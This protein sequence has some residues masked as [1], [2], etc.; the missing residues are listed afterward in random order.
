MNKLIL[1]LAVLIGSNAYA[2]SGIAT[3]NTKNNYK[4]LEELYLEAELFESDFALEVNSIE[5]YKIEEE[6]ILNFD[7]RM[8]L[9]EDF[10]P[11]KGIH[12]LDWNTI[13]LVEF[14]EEV[15][16]DFDT[17]KHLPKNFNAI[18][19]MYELNWNAIELVEVEEEVELGFDTEKYL[20]KDFN[21]YKGLN[22]EKEVVV[23]LY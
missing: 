19:G 11:L 6:I 10:N 22:C 16:L 1:L 14:E 5:V 3:N 20:P 4:T 2:I 21:P 7:T 13:E 9:P 15:E 8:Y 17:K 12:N 18:S 23:S